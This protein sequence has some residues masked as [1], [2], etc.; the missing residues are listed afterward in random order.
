MDC[1]LCTI[2][3]CYLLCLCC[4]ANQIVL[5]SLQVTLLLQVYVP[6]NPQKH[7]RLYFFHSYNFG[8]A[9]FLQRT[10]K[11]EFFLMGTIF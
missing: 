2:E 9:F 4:A 6:Q 1:I 8:K 11:N 3:Q 10:T 5:S 7:T